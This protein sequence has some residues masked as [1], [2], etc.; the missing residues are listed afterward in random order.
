MLFLIFFQFLY[1]LTRMLQRYE[2]IYCYVYWYNLLFLFY[3]LSNRENLYMT[4]HDS[5][6]FYNAFN[7]K[8]IQ[9]KIQLLSFI[10]FLSWLTQKCFWFLWLFCLWLLDLLFCFKKI[11]YIFSNVAFRL[12]F[13]F[14]LSDFSFL[15]SF[16]PLYTLLTLFG[17]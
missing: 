14:S 3:F 2:N 12:F 13:V 5:S 1:D 9:S 16:P 17:L 6:L 8:S 10:V 7:S 4:H 15:I 11:S